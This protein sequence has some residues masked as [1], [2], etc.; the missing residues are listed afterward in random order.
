MLT[1][2]QANNH[3]QKT[4]IDWTVAPDNKGNG[5]TIKTYPCLK[6]KHIFIQL[7]AED[8]AHNEVLKKNLFEGGLIVL[9]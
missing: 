8:T 6:V 9:S 2:K 5:G 3:V 1:I 4:T 7:L